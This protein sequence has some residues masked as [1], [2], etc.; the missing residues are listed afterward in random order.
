MGPTPSAKNAGA[1]APAWGGLALVAVA[2]LAGGAS[3]ANAAPLAVIELAALPVLALAIRRLANTPGEGRQGLIVVLALIVAVPLAQLI[4][5]PPEVWTLAPGQ[6]VRVRALEVLGLPPGWRPLSLYP[7]ATVGCALALLPPAAVAL[8]GLAMRGQDRHA[9]AMTWIALALAGLALGAA[10]MTEPAG[11]SVYLYGETNVG[12][13]VGFF[14]NRNHEAALLL[15]LLPFAAD[16]AMWEAGGARQG[17]SGTVVLALIF[18]ALALI[19]LGV[20]RSRAGVVLAAPAALGALAVLARGRAGRARLAT[21][22]GVGALA[23][24]LVSLFALTP[25]IERFAPSSEGEFRFQAWPSVV[26]AAE[27]FQPLGAGVG[28]FERIFRAAEPLDLVRP[29]FFNH[30]HNDYLEI[31]LE[32]GWSGPAVLF[33][34]LAWFARAAARAWGRGGES[35]ARAASVSIVILMAASVVDYPLRTESLACLFAFACAALVARAAPVPPRDK[36]R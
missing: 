11:G 2:A 13:L 5:L 16:L 24:L 19:S 9:V 23:T 35:Q 27:P 14:A 28:A 18:A 17:W 26:A 20:V 10:Q 32:T 21:A 31:W 29:E 22:V 15:A 36:A 4:P 12:S 34:F 3:R 6:I 25:L 30:A 7:H 8:A 1:P 33:L